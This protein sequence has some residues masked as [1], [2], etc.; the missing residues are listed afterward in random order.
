MLQLLLLLP[1]GILAGLLSG[2]LGIG[3]GLI[4]SPLLL[5]LG[6]APHQALAT[7]TLAIVPTTAA[8]AW[9][10]WRQG[11]LPLPPSLAIG[12][13]AL[14]SAPIFASVGRILTDWHLLA[15]Q[16]VMYA[17]VSFSVRPRQQAQ[18]ATDAIPPL[19]LAGLALL[20]LVAGMAGGLLGL[21][22][23]L[24]MVP[25]MVNLLQVPIHLA[26]RLSTVA[27]FLASSG[28]GTLLVVEGRALLLPALLLGGLASL[29]SRWAAARLQRISPQRLAWLL[30]L[31]AMALTV[32]SG[33][34]AVALWLQ[35]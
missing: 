4:F 33:R 18:E 30:R 25:L 21:G 32:D 35:A 13:A 29:A 2:L 28:A 31:L 9:A 11:R 24:V 1:L 3:G 26:I 7:S 10:H 12:L 27:V 19:P 22:G 6:L 34:R 8:G 5:A 17:L 23:G 16:A 14:I 20:G 15:L